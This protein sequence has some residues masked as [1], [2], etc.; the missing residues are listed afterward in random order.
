GDELQELR[1]DRIIPDSTYNEIEKYLL[2]DIRK[3]QAPADKMFNKTMKRPVDLL[4]RLMFSKKVVDDPARSVFGTMRR[5]GHLS[6]LGFRAKPTLRNL[7]QRLLLQDLY[8]TRDYA[9]A[10]AVAFRLSDMPNTE[11]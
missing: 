6:G 3:H 11:H 5:I 7:G 1:K 9:K 2:Y 10:Q 4:G 8:R